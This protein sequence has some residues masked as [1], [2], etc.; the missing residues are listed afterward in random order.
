M[1]R[2]DFTQRA[3]E[4]E[5]MDQ[6]GVSR[7][8][9]KK[10]LDELSII[11]GR[12]GGYVVT[13]SALKS[14]GLKNEINIVDYGCGGGDVL[15]FIYDRALRDKVTVHCNGIDINPEMINYC[16][17]H[18]ENRII[19]YFQYS[20][21]ENELLTIPCDV[22]INSL[23]CHHFDNKDLVL[24]IKKMF[25]H[26]KRAVI[27]NDLHRHPLAYYSI[28]LLTRLFSRSYLVKFDGPLSVARALTKEEWVAVIREAGITDFSIKWQWAFR[29]QIIL[30]K[31]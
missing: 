3:T 12:L 5:L 30:H 27:L 15:R 16:R 8:E 21:W 22:A 18:N 28:R 25:T 10:A 17:E 29:W 2:P 11:N 14:L 7:D 24:L 4:P 23:F 1:K 26:S 20:I 19:N 6:P 31:R 13:W 9:I